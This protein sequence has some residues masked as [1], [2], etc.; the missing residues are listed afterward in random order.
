METASLNP[1]RRDFLSSVVPVSALA[2]LGCKN[3][4]GFFGSAFGQETAAHKFT[5][6][7]QMSFT[8]VFDFAFRYYYIPILQG[9]RG[10]VGDGDFIEML[11]KASEESGRSSAEGFAR[12]LPTNDFEAFKSWAREADRFSQHA[13]TFE[14]V[15]DSDTALEVKIT[16]CLWAKTFREM[17]A[18]D[19]GYA[20]ICH[21]DFAYAE[22]YNPK[23]RMERTRTLMQGDDHCDHRWLWEV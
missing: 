23:L 5:A 2:C 17:E 11:K 6:D 7:S 3:L 10:Q 22:G 21:G 14:I 1:T 12:S 13:L 19:I 8:E 15:E 16:E 9:L 4:C 18:S 20:G